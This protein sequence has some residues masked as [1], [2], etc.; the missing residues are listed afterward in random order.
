MRTETSTLG[1]ILLAKGFV[2]EDMLADAQFEQ[3]AVHKPL[4]ATHE[5]VLAAIDQYRNADDTVERVASELDV[6]DEPEGGEG[7]VD[8]EADRGRCCNRS[9]P[10]SR[11]WRG[12]AHVA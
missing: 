1:E 12:H 6:S 8:R 5:D 9:D 3:R 4:V 2:T 11:T 10:R 7:W